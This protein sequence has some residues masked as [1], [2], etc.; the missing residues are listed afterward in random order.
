ML[1]EYAYP[2][3]YSVGNKMQV[4]FNYMRI[5]IFVIK[6]VGRAS[7]RYSRRSRVR[8]SLKIKFFSAFF[9]PIAGGSGPGQESLVLHFF[10][11]FC[12]LKRKL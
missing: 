12:S 11:F 9:F 10:F 7:H 5:S 8:I 2:L 3:K 4:V 1:I 6:T